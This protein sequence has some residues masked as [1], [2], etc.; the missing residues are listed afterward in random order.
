MERSS[1][2]HVLKYRLRQRLKQRRH[3]ADTVGECSSR[4]SQSMVPHPGSDPVYWTVAGIALQQETP[5]EAD[6]IGRIAEQAGNRG[7]CDL[8]RSQRTVAGLLPP[9]APHFANMCLDLDLDELGFIAP[10]LHVGRTAAWAEPIFVRWVVGLG[11]A[12]E[13]RARR[14][15]MPR[16]T[17]LLAAIAGAAALVFS[18]FLAARAKPGFGMGRVRRAEP[19]ICSLEFSNCFLLPGNHTL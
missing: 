3:S 10:V 18:V 15:S 16:L 14:P 7:R 6:P 11:L 5:P 12:L 13:V 4:Y 17:R 8:L 9:G 2:L 1:G 19:L